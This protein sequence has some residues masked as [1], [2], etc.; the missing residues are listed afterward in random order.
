M[1]ILGVAILVVG[2][3]AAILFYRTSTGEDRLRALHPTAYKALEYRYCDALYDWYI[4]KVQQRFAM[5]VSLLDTVFVSGLGM[6]AIVAGI[7]ATV[8]SLIRRFVHTG[9]AAVSVFWIAAGALIV[10]LLL[11]TGALN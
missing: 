7:P 8:G 4:A 9:N 11:I 3:V 1:L 10:A 2:F 6:R 5:F